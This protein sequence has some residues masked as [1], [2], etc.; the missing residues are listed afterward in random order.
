[1]SPIALGLCCEALGLSAE[2]VADMHESAD[3][4]PALLAQVALRLRPAPPVCDKKRDLLEAIHRGWGDKPFTAG[5]LIAWCKQDA[6]PL[7]RE[8]LS[9][10]RVVCAVEDGGALDA[11]GLGMRL[12][13]LAKLQGGAVRLERGRLVGGALQWSVRDSRD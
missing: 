9:A 6:T 7:Q 11:I 10:A 8:V 2:E 12:S 1:M 5:E 4:L 13:T 3:L